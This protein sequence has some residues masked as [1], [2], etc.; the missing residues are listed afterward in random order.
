MSDRLKALREERAKIVKE[1]RDLLDKADA[2]KRQPTAEENAKHT[3][4]FGKQDDLR[5]RIES[6]QRQVELDRE[7]ATDAV[8]KDKREKPAGKDK[9][10]GGKP[11]ASI[12][13]R[14]FRKFLLGDP[15]NA[16]ETRALE[17]TTDSKGGYT[18]APEQFVAQLIKNVDDQVFIRGLATK[19]QVTSA[20]SLGVPTLTADPAD[21]DWTTEL[22]VG[23]EDTTMA[24]GKRSLTP[25][26]IGKYIKIS[27]KLMR[28]SALPIENIVNSRLAY[29]FAISEEKAFLTGSGNNQPL[30][31]FTA[32]ND[33][34][35]T[36]QDVST[37]NTGTSITFDGLI[38]AKYALKGQYWSRA[39]WLFHR[40]AVA[41]VAKLKDGEGQYLWRMSVRDGEP[42]MLLG[43]PVNI[44]EY[45][46]NTF[47]T[48]LYVGML[49][50][51]SNY[52]IVDALSMTVQRLVELYALTN[53]DALIGRMEIDGM[54]VLAESF[55]RVKLG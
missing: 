53:Q 48:G 34:V 6:E 42:D 11:D 10:E 22:A 23:S 35:P 14:G 47:T 32:S 30:G 36:T 28:A 41:Q 15:L 44:S 12:E 9:P 2:E 26:P 52:W 50:D 43:R 25:H 16:E 55:V 17:A 20:D 21:S 5:N 24:F 45:A 13:M 3:E 33:G 8:E 29:K 18:V 27:K 54:P 38:S 51:F 39:Q 37:G 19:Y 4:L 46:P 7:M 49:A 1:M 31:V 40:D